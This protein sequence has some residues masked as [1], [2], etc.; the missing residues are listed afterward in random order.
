ML[1][2]GALGTPLLIERT[3]RGFRPLLIRGALP[4]S[5]RPSFGRVGKE[6]GVEGGRSCDR[7]HADGDTPFVHR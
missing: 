6:L 4:C 7:V 5:R 2:I 3:D 1:S